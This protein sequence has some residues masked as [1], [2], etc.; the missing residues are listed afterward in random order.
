M[1][2]VLLCDD[3]LSVTNFLKTSIAWEGLGIQN[4]YTAAD[5]QEALSLFETKQIDLLIT[6][7]RM[8]RMDGLHLLEAVREISPDTHCILLTAYGEFEY[9]R[10]AFRLGVDN[11]LLKPIQLEELTAT[12]ENTVENMYLHRQNQNNLLR[13]NLLRRWL[14]GNISAD[15]LGERSGVL[16]GINVYQSAYLAA[17]INKTD[18]AVS[19]SAYAEACFRELSLFCDCLSVWDNRG[20]FVLILGGHTLDRTEIARILE[21][22]A[23]QLHISDHIYMTV[24]ITADQCTGLSQSYQSAVRLLSTCR[25]QSGPVLI[26]LADEQKPSLN[27]PEIPD[28]SIDFENLSPII[29]KAVDYIHANYTEG[30]SIKEFCATHTV[31]PA[32]LGY[33]FKKETNVF[34]NNY[35]NSYRLSKA[36]EMLVSTQERVNVIAEKCGFTST[37]YFITSFKKFTGMSPQ[38]YRELYQ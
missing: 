34:F 10:T 32:H 21:Q 19:L 25:E 16:G 6:D 24:G 3:E 35:L 30:V 7:I 29:R 9:A 14:S 17:C 26:R 2:Q 12:L 11:Y 31:T 8:P 4:V 36:Q 1:F 37:S 13:E 20:C 27:P 22:T 23:H 38:K 15:E 18:P 5:G 28:I 33:L